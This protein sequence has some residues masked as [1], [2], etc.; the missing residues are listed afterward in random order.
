MDGRATVCSFPTDAGDAR[1][2]CLRFAESVE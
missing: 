2:P 1:S